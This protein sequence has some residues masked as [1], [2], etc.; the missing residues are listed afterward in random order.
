MAVVTAIFFALI[1]L[2]AALFT[3]LNGVR[4][5]AST[6]AVAVRTRA[7]TPGIA[8]VLAGFFNLLGALLSGGLALALH[9]QLFVL[10]PGAE[11]LSIILA[12]LIAALIWGIQQWWIGY[13]SSSTHALLGGIGGAAGAAMLKGAPGLAGL[14]STLIW[15]VVL[16]LLVSPVIAFAASYLLVF[17][18]AW[19]S[20]Y[21]QP[22]NIN[23]RFRRAQAVAAG[24]VAFGHGLQDGSRITTL[25]L[26]AVVAAGYGDLDGAIWWLAC[27]VGIFLTLGTLAGGWRIGYTLS[28]R[29]VKVDPMRGFVAQSVSAVMLLIGSIGLHLP[30]ATTQLTTASIIG[31]GVNQRFSVTN[32]RLAGKILLSW[33]ATPVVSAVISGVLY[34][35]LSSLM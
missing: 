17:P 4:D 28:S 27:A 12:A 21:A 15:L 30:L 9:D 19:F 5:V 2:F 16:P 3:M 8:V 24:S 31:A 18:I 10:R 33:F 34:L 7:L 20:R 35:A 25:L 11:G 14:D 1:C 22:N 13:P 32:G 23:R 6:I 29:L 26:F